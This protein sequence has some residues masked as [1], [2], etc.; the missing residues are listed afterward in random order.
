MPPSTSVG[1][2][3]RRRTGATGTTTPTGGCAGPTA[4]HRLT[5]AIMPG[6]CCCQVEQRCDRTGA[7]ACS[8]G[9]C[10]SHVHHAGGWGTSRTCADVRATASSRVGVRHGS[11]LPL[12]LADANR[13][14]W[15]RHTI[16]VLVTTS[17]ATAPLPSTNEAGSDASCGDAGI[18]RRCDGGH[19]VQVRH[20]SCLGLDACL[21]TCQ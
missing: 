6:L 11:R 16:A 2:V 17:N 20:R 1:G 12:T 15:Q 21:D 18:G 3:T 10:V 4:R 13:G 8:P 5:P 7:V 9:R 14:R 19:R